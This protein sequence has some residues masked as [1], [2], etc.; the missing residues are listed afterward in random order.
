LLV[1]TLLVVV[2]PQLSTLTP[3]KVRALWNTAVNAPALAMACWAAALAAYTYASSRP[4]P[5]YLVD[6]AGY[7]PPV[8]LE[9]SRAKTIVHFSRCGRFSEQSMAFQKRMLERS[10]LG[11]ATH[12]PMSLIRLPVDM[13]DR[14]AMEESHAV[15]FG[16]VDEVLRKTGVDA[17]DVGVLI[18]NS[19]LLSPTPSFT[20]LIVNRY[21]FR[22][23]IVTH[24]L[25]GMGCSAGIIAI[26]LAKR[27]LQVLMSSECIGACMHAW[28]ANSWSSWAARM[29]ACMS[30]RCVWS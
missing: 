22:D 16:V 18:F 17:G 11:E 24:N 19:S 20:S 14:T 7:K 15:I 3:E 5:V 10:G 9:A 2:A 25:S 12:F 13:C 28:A 21:E 1:V 6:L 27:L 8:E 29:H 23:D 4:Q 26:D 30:F